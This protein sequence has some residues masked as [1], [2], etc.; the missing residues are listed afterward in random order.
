[1]CLETGKKARYGLTKQKSRFN[2]RRPIQMLRTDLGS[3]MVEE[4]LVQIDEGIYT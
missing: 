3:R 1:M 4:M 2:E